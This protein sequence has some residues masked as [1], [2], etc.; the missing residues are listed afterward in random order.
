RSPDLPRPASSPAESSLRESESFRLSFLPS[1]GF[2]CAHWFTRSKK[3]DAPAKGWG[4]P[5]LRRKKERLPDEL[6]PERVEK[7]REHEPEG[8]RPEHE[9]TPNQTRLLMENAGRL[10]KR[11]QGG[12]EHSDRSPTQ[13]AVV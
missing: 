11:Q 9:T 10:G 12:K 6:R 7:N 4:R 3:P 8:Q 13:R 2:A 5:P 1:K